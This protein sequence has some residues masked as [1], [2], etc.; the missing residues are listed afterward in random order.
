MSFDPIELTAAIPSVN[1]SD[2]S[3]GCLHN[4]LASSIKKLRIG[5]F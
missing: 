1:Q 3:F 4:A 5:A 2:T